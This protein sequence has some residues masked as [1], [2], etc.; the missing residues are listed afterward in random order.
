MGEQTDA[1]ARAADRDRW[2]STKVEG[3]PRA[4]VWLVHGTF[5]EKAP[6][7][8]PGHMF[9]MG[10]ST[11]FPDIA[12]RRFEWSGKN[13]VYARE[14]AAQDLVKHVKGLAR[15]HPGKPQ[16]VI[17]HSHGGNIALMTSHRLGAT[18]GLAGLACISTPFI[19]ARLQDRKLWTIK[20]LTDAFFALA[21]AIV[22]P[23]VLLSGGSWLVLLAALTACVFIG[24]GLGAFFYGGLQG[25][26]GSFAGNLVASM[27]VPCGPRNMLILR[28]PGDE[29]SLALGFSQFLSWASSRLFERLSDDIAST[30]RTG[31]L[32]SS[33]VLGI[34]KAPL[35]KWYRA[36]ARAMI[37]VALLALAVAVLPSTPDETM[38]LI[39]A[40]PLTLLMVV[41][42]ALRTTWYHRYFFAFAFTML[43]LFSSVAKVFWIGTN[44][45][46]A[47]CRDANLRGPKGILFGLLLALLLD[48]DI[49]AS[50][51]GSST[52][53]LVPPSSG[54]EVNK[55]RHSAYDNEAVQYALFNWLA[56]SLAAGSGPGGDGDL[57]GV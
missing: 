48:I 14:M 31:L 37:T 36:F 8:M 29:A 6:W 57:A 46:E 42:L 18:A 15:L 4:I 17:A 9:H 55:F 24:N 7:T 44:P 39:V 41:Y 26:A 28:V 40:A 21:I 22:I 32:W 11:R 38:G 52:V 49:E 51:K 3:A 12:I 23:I 45:R 54:H 50:P 53:T 47:L 56:Q 5:A 10:L 20:N 34:K 30:T 16:Y 43:L 27:Q 19:L 2:G 35:P 25:V 33:A 1:A 13:D